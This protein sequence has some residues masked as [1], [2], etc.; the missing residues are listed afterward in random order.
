[1][2]EESPGIAATEQ[3]ARGTEEG[4]CEVAWEPMAQQSVRGSACCRRA[5]VYEPHLP[6]ERVY[7]PHSWARQ[8][9]AEELWPMEVRARDES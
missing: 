4:S 3:G 5:R 8:V 2:L 6:G 9:W 1:M 7:E